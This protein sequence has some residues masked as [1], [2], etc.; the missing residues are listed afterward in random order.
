MLELL[1]VKE[2]IETCPVKWHE[3]IPPHGIS[4]GV[5]DVDFK[6]PDGIIEYI[7]SNIHEG[8][9]FYQHQGGQPDT[10]KILQDYFKVRGIEAKSNNLQI[11]PGTMLGIYAAMKWAS[12]R[13]GKIIMLGPLYEPIHRHATDNNNIID[14]VDIHPDGLDIDMLREKVTSDTKMIAIN[15]PCNPIGYI[16]KREELEIIRD[17]AIELDLVVFS[18]ELY[19]PL[20][21][22]DK[23]HITTASIDGLAERTIALYGFSK[24][25]GLAG[26]RSG[27][28]YLG[29]KVSEEVKHIVE[30]QL[31]SPSPIASLVTNFALTSQ[32]SKKW[33]DE[34]RDHC[35]RVTKKAA[36]YL[37]DNNVEC[38]IPNGCFFIYPNIGI[39]DVKFCEDLL[40]SEGVQ[41]IPG[42]VFGPTG[43]NHL[44]INCATS[45][46]RLMSGLS[47]MLK[48][49]KNN[50]K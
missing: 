26:F 40:K 28:M 10:I 13:E 9:N 36:Q 5:A 41:I 37:N 18:D 2:L 35:E 46:E 6:G 23:K 4:L 16:Y 14:W 7:R 48:E 25:Y 20:V 49:L 17:L 34:F 44:R 42:S 43:K 32:T 27:F 47:K 12:R 39:D 24:A 30:S 19:E 29:D 8:H 3:N 11:I 38:V 33:V 15:N 50:Q 1:S 45:E 31:I 22:Y 21:F